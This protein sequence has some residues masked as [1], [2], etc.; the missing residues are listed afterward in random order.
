M[1]DL[2]TSAR[3]E[4]VTQKEGRTAPPPVAVIEQ[5]KTRRKRGAGL[6]PISALKRLVESESDSMTAAAEKL[7]MP[8]STLATYMRERKCPLVVELAAAQVMRAPL[9]KPQTV[10]IVQPSA[11]QEEVV[12]TLLKALHVKVSKLEVRG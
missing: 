11:E 8:I 2:G 7:G 1:A 6:I 3:A 9:T 12:Q 10:L 4:P 5:K